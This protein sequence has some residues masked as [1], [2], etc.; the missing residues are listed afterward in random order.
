MSISEAEQQ[1][2]RIYRKTAQN[3]FNNLLKQYLFLIIDEPSIQK[4]HGEAAVQVCR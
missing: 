1:N 2:N 3:F 4:A